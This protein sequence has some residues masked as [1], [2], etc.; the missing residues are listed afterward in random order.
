MNGDCSI[1]LK[2]TLVLAYPATDA[3]IPYHFGP[4]HGLHT[5]GRHDVFLFQ[6]DGFIGHR[7]HLLA[8]DTVPP[9]L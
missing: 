9:S 2:G 7:A 1:S 4:A 8:D 3:L 5:V 6:D